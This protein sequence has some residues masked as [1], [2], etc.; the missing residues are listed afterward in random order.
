M[1]RRSG[2]ALDH[3]DAGNNDP[4]GAHSFDQPIEQDAPVGQTDGFALRPGGKFCSRR[5]GEVP[6]TM[7]LLDRRQLFI[8]GG[9]T[10]SKQGDRFGIGADLFCDMIEHGAR[11]EFATPKIST[12]ERRQQ[13]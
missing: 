6:K 3:A 4:L 5:P 1:H 7:A 9:S 13:S 11:Q 2:H 10:S 12:G 8:S